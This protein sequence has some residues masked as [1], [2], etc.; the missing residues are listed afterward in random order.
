MKTKIKQNVA[1]IL[2]LL[3]LGSIVT[4]CKN[5]ETVTIIYRETGDTVWVTLIGLERYDHIAKQYKPDTITD[6]SY[7]GKPLDVFL[8]AYMI[9]R[10]H[11]NKEC[12][13]AESEVIEGWYLYSDEK[14]I[15]WNFD[16][17]IPK[18]APDSLTF[19]FRD[20]AMLIFDWGGKGGK[21]NDT[22]WFVSVP[23][24]TVQNPTLPTD[25]P[26]VDDF[27]FGGWNLNCDRLFDGCGSSWS[28]KGGPGV[29]SG[30]DS[31]VFIT[32]PAIFSA[33]WIPKGYYK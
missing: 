5:E 11:G 21:T 8:N 6:V 1:I 27:D 25:I 15:R 19:Y 14:Y 2:V 7:K 4:T 10:C 29:Y 33:R 12:I 31:T 3:I 28:W 16:S 17:I 32:L 30:T 9:S 22:F 18:D 26:V 20:E 13:E 23:P 24:I